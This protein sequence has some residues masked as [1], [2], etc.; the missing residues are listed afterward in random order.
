MSDDFCLSPTDSSI[1]FFYPDDTIIKEHYAIQKHK[2]IIIF[3]GRGMTDAAFE[4]LFRLMHSE[5]E[6]KLEN[7]MLDI[8]S[9]AL[10]QKSVG[11][12]KQLLDLN[13]K[14]LA[15]FNGIGPNNSRDSRIHACFT[16]QQRMSVS[17]EATTV[18]LPEDVN[19]Q[20]VYQL[21]VI[22]QKQIEKTQKQIEKT[23][24]QL[25]KTTRDIRALS[26]QVKIN[27]NTLKKLS[28]KRERDIAKAIQKK[29]PTFRVVS[30]E[31]LISWNCELSKHEIDILLLSAN[32][33][34]MVV[35]EAKDDL[36]DNEAFKQMRVRKAACEAMMEFPEELPDALKRLR[37]V[38]GLVG[39]DIIS[40]ERK[41]QSRKRDLVIAVKYNDYELEND[42]AIEAAIRQNI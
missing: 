22:S 18:L 28:F 33:S 3:R 7:K 8:S 29:Y 11:F 14:V 34:I 20:C 31:E 40:D 41:E 23:Q 13:I 26:Q 38:I 10:T 39:A 21:Q 2:D 25:E 5:T 35:G 6:V 1:P 42:G 24:K 16:P 27:K 9:N 36:N 30:Q 19:L 15:H 17:V 32:G 37:T 4:F 12:I